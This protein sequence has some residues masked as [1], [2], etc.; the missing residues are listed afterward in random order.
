MALPFVLQQVIKR[1]GMYLPVVEFDVAAGLIQG[2]DLASSG[3]LLVGFR[4]WLVL[5]LGYGNNLAWPGLVFRLAFP[6]SASCQHPIPGEQQKC[7]VDSL[8][9]LLE[10]FWQERESDH[11]LRRIYLR[12]QE[13]L[14]C[15][16]WYEPGSPDWIEEEASAVG[17]GFKKSL[18]K[19]K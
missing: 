12:Y 11:G 5:K 15:Q 2:F 18:K 6:D 17:Q 1:P 10:E 7:A 3:G 9:G 19:A 13:W 14:K 8:F 16:D 4:E